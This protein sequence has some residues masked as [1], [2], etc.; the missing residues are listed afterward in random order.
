MAPAPAAP[1]HLVDDRAA[2]V[3]AQIVDVALVPAH[4]D[5]RDRVGDNV[6]RGRAFTRDGVRQPQQATQ[7]NSVASRE[8]LDV[9]L[10][11]HTVTDAWAR[12]KVPEPCDPGAPWYGVRR[13]RDAASAFFDAF[14]STM[15][16]EEFTPTHFAANDDDVH[17][18]VHMPRSVCDALP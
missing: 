7:L 8:C 5:A 2:E 13:G 18:V 4:P 1:D 15:E 3:G 12:Q 16:V 11:G 9:S 6:L 14:G 10:H 17:T